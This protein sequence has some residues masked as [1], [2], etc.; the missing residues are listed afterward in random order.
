[1]RILILG[2][3]GQVGTEL[4]NY[5][6]NEPEVLAL[7]RS[8]DGG[9]LTKLD[10]LCDR[11]RSYCPNIVF[12]AAAY[13]AVDK[14]ETDRDLAYI[15][16]AEAVGFIAKACEEVGAVLVHYSTDY[17]FDGEGSEMHTE[18]DPTAPLNYY[19][20][21]KLAGEEAIQATNAK[22]LIFRT[23]WVYSVHGHNFIKTMLCLAKT[24]DAL[25]VV[26][27]Q[28]GAP[29]SATMIAEVSAQLGVRVAKGEDA[30]CGL[31]NLVPHGETSWCELARY[32]VNY[33]EKIGVKQVLRTENIKGI[34]TLEYFTSARRPLNSRLNNQKMCTIFDGEI[35]DWQFY[36]D[37]V[38]ESLVKAE[39]K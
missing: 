6:R 34:S 17:V 12:N 31:Y 23:S 8:D 27:D 29:T 36:V 14:A 3:N 16:N 11:I 2:K 32:V 26:A 9:D 38:I 37:Q 25:N 28:I 10:S 30:L 7:D 39:E 33:A 20:I 15:V 22:V 13:T 1:M 35:Y 4:Q 19:G 5:F 21:T 24:K 18:S